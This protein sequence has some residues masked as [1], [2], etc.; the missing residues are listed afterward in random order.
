M[1]TKS[2]TY[3]KKLLNLSPVNNMEGQLALEHEYQTLAG[4]TTDYK[5][6]GLNAFFGEAEVGV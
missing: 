4:S 5:K 1:P 6:E 2:I 3:T